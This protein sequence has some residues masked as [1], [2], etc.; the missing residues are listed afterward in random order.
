MFEA[1]NACMVVGG[2]PFLFYD[3]LS[4]N[5]M[6]ICHSKYNDILVCGFYLSREG[7]HS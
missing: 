6:A 7:C 4:N 1:I 2:K 5:T 3:A